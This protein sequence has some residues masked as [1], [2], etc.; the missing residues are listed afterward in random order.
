MGK[1][2]IKLSLLNKNDHLQDVVTVFNNPLPTHD[3]VATTGEKFIL[4]LY[5]A[6]TERDLNRQ[7]FI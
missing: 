4:T 3:E 6:P 1:E 7:R 2:K 5:N